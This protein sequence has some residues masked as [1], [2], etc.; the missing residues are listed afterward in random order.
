MSEG[1]KILVTGGAGYIGS[2]TVVSLVEQGFEPVIVDNFSNSSEYVLEGLKTITG[3]APVYYRVDVCDRAALKSV[4]EEH[5]FFG[6]IHFAAFKAVGESVETPIKY[7]RNNMLG[8]MNCVELAEEFKVENF[9]FSSSCTV[10]GEPAE[11]NKFVTEK[12]PLSKPMSPYATTKIMGEQLID[13]VHRAGFTMRFLKLRYFNPVGAHPS[14]N[15][16]ELPLGRPNNL[17]PAVAQVASGKLEE[18]VVHGRDYHTADGTC[19]RDYI[20]V[21]DVA[22]AHVKGLEWLENQNKGLCEVV[23]I[24]RGEGA[25]V[26]EIIHT[27]EEVSGSPLNWRFGPRRPGDIEEIYA[28]VSKSHELLNWK[29]SRSIADAVR[30]TWHWEQRLRNG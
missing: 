28:D 13:D 8:L 25:S 4:F 14:G 3:I 21:C 2:H 23:N 20:H 15:I 17:M 1:R 10:Y 6:V 18:L 22:D 11:G 19:V 12:T 9:V 16:G 27:F 24:G 7:Y 26:L 5:D 30:D 29:A